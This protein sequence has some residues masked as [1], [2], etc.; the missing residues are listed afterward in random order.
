MQPP[1]D[2]AH[3]Y[4]L[5]WGPEMRPQGTGSQ[6]RR[7]VTLIVVAIMMGRTVRT[8]GI[9]RRQAWAERRS[10]GPAWRSHLGVVRLLLPLALLAG[11]ALA[12]ARIIALRR[13]TVP[14][15]R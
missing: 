13:S 2:A 9:L 10:P 15:D 1:T 5:G 14:A 8:V 7:N 6:H 11:L 4:G 3:D 12:A